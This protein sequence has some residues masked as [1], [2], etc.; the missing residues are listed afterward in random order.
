MRTVETPPL[1]IMSLPI[2]T[3][4]WTDEAIASIPLM[5]TIN[6][7]NWTTTDPVPSVDAVALDAGDREVQDFS[8]CT[9]NSFTISGTS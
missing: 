9:S 3:S 5:N 8:I 4:G 2:D 7:L 6:N 1:R